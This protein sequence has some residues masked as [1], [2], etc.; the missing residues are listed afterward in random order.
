[1]DHEHVHI[2]NSPAGRKSMT[3]FEEEVHETAQKWDTL[4]GVKYIIRQSPR[5]KS[6]L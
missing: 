2:H 3:P 1:M 5:G 4:E 6:P